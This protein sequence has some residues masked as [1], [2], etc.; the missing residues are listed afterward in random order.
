MW[1]ELF[2][3]IWPI[4]LRDEAKPESR[5]AVIRAKLRAAGMVETIRSTT[6]R[7]VHELRLSG[8]E[9]DVSA[10]E[11]RQRIL[12]SPAFSA[13]HALMLARR[14]LDRAGIFARIQRGAAFSLKDAGRAASG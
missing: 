5:A 2:D 1:R 6:R 9:G 14:E 11:L 12:D 8:I 4:L 3:E 10:N 7:V 13:L